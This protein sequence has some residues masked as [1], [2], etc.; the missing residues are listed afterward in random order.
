MNYK[1]VRVSVLRTTSYH[2]MGN[3]M[4]ERFNRTLLEML[5]T[6]EQHQKSNW[7]AYVAPMVHALQVCVCHQ[8]KLPSLGLCRLSVS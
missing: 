1:V 8:R 3:G 7:K 2:P 6:M 4:C 5:G